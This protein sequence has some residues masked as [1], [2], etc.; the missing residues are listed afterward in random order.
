L[1]RSNPGRARHAGVPAPVLVDS[2][3]WIAFLSAKDANHDA[4]D[5]V[6]RAAVARGVPLVTTD[7]VLAEV[8][9][10]L[11]FR[12]GIRPA[13]VAIGRIVG[14]PSVKLHFGTNDHHQRAIAWLD[15]LSDQAV[16]YTDAVSFAVMESLRIRA[17]LSFDRHFWVAGFTPWKPALRGVE[18]AR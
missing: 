10:L 9:R 3:A 11:L 4:A 1:P 12:A 14:S 17:A 18:R 5:E 2:S 8:H 6:L 16:S 15:R 13:R 7:L